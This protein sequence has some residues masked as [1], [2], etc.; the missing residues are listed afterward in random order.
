MPNYQAND[1]K[2]VLYDNMTTAI[3]ADGNSSEIDFGVAGGCPDGELVFSILDRTT[4]ESVTLIVQD[5]LSGSF[6]STPLR[7]HGIAANG[8]YV[9]PINN[10]VITGSKLRI[11]HDVTLPSGSNGLKMHGH[12]R[13]KPAS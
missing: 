2:N 3:T 8:V 12:F 6:S 1:I 4:G 7:L 5:Y 13:P 11:N 10:R 9:I